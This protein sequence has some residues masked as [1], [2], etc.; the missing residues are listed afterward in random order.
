LK[1]QLSITGEI[2]APSNGLGLEKLLDDRVAEPGPP[3]TVTAL[4]AM[5]LVSGFQRDETAM[6][7]KLFERL[8]NSSVYNEHGMENSF[9][10]RKAWMYRYS[11]Q[12]N[13][14]SSLDTALSS[15]RAGQIESAS[16]E[17]ELTKIRAISVCG[18][19][20]NDGR[21]RGPRRGD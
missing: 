7:N 20:P 3:A 12:V 17:S 18:C 8:T 9:L 15:G 10:L 13:P 11:Q 1:R 19:A 21:Q 16:R 14:N 5:N 6:E 4:S 2:R